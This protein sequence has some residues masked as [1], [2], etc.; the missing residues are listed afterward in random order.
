MGTSVDTAKMPP[1]LLKHL[2]DTFAKLAPCRVLWK[3]DTQLTNLPSNVRVETWLPQQDI[4]GELLNDY[5]AFSPHF[6][7]QFYYLLFAGHKNIKAFVTHAGLHGIF[8]TVYHGV[9][10]I[11][12]P[13]FFDQDV[14]AASAVADGY[15]IKI[16]MSELTADKLSRAIKR[17]SENPQYRE[18]VQ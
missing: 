16:E 3:F 11:A 4:L 5:C 15:C 17:V 18:A 12:M 2:L 14:I 9:P 7:S 10:V 8:E 6:L 13:V 1:Q